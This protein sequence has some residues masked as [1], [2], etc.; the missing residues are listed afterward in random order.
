MSQEIELL[1]GTDFEEE[2]FELDFSHL[3][4]RYISHE[5]VVETAELEQSFDGFSSGDTR[6]LWSEDN[7]DSADNWLP[8]FR[9]KSGPKIEVT[10]K[11]IDIFNEFFD[12]SQFGRQ[13][14]E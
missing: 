9:L 10:D 11:P 5:E 8:K 7:C 13:L 6:D 4:D 2:V 1:F 12:F 14:H 3:N